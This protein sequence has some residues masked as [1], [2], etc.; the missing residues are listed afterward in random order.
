[1]SFD[2]ILDLT[3]GVYFNFYNIKIEMRFSCEIEDFV[4][5]HL[6]KL[7]VILR[8][9]NRRALSVM[10]APEYFGALLYASWKP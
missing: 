2:E 7:C 1:M 9:I 10:N 3:A 4:E 6:C 5:T 8:S